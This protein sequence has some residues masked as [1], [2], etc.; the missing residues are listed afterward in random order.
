MTIQA[1]ALAREREEGLS[2]HRAAA[3]AAL[4]L[5]TQDRASGRSAP[6]GQLL[7]LVCH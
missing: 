3:P 6:S 2:Y 1:I 5:L 4:V 7:P